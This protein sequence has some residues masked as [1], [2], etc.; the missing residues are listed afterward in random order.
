MIQCVARTIV[1]L[2]TSPK[3]ENNERMKRQEEGARNPEGKDEFTPQRNGEWYLT[4][5]DN[6]KSKDDASEV[7]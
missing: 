5:K 4:Q 2:D 3:V 6:R 7:E 1:K